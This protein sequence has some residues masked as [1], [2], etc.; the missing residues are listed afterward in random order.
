[1]SG[2]IGSVDRNMTNDD[3]YIVTE[4]DSFL[5]IL[6]KMQWLSC[7]VAM[8]AQCCFQACGAACLYPLELDLRLPVITTVQRTHIT[9]G[10]I[11]DYAII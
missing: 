7:K 2:R 10:W 5:T 1:M 4:G 6:Q 3:S 11:N 8:A 9:N